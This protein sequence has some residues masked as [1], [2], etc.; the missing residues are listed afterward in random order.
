[1]HSLAVGSACIPA[2]AFVCLTAQ[3]YGNIPFVDRGDSDIA[4]TIADS[5]V[6][7]LERLLPGEFSDASCPARGRAAERLRC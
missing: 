2:K 4:L 1:M 6:A 3:Q 5:S 7:R